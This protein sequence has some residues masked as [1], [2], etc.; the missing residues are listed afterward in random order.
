MC[1]KTQVDIGPQLDSQLNATSRLVWVNY[2]GGAKI[3]MANII[4]VSIARLAL[5]TRG[6]NTHNIEMLCVSMT[7]CANSRNVLVPE[8]QTILFVVISISS[9]IATLS[10]AFIFLLLFH[11][12]ITTLVSVSLGVSQSITS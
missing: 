6:E 9:D 1:S 10:N 11:Y 3:E 12:C 7:N 4:E 8:H 5:M 2:V